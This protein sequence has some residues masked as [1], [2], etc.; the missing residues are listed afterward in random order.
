MPCKNVIKTS[1]KK[2]KPSEPLNKYN[3]RFVPVDPIKHAPSIVTASLETAAI[4]SQ[5]FKLE[6]CAREKS[7]PYAKMIHNRMILASIDH[8]IPQVDIKSVF[9][10]AEAT[11]WLLKNIIEKLVSRS[12]FKNRIRTDFLFDNYKQNGLISKK[13]VNDYEK[14]KNCFT[15]DENILENLYNE[16]N[17]SKNLDDENEQEF[18][19]DVDQSD[20]QELKEISDDMNRINAKKL[21]INL[22]D[23]K[24][25]L[26]VCLFLCLFFLL[27]FL[28]FSL[29]QIT[30][31]YIHVWTSYLH[32]KNQ[33]L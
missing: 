16:T 22:Y 19:M 24:N 1:K 7:L 29:N 30:Y 13:C 26:Q 18:K 2:V 12:K 9:L 31:V 5:D 20:L 28:S 8:N 14:L 23:L 32:F 21:P 11:I 3:L 27:S 10:L 17:P 33:I 6:F 25:L 15:I 4:A